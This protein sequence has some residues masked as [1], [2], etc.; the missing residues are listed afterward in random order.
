MCAPDATVTS[1]AAATIAMAHRVAQ[2]K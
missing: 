1:T 2:E